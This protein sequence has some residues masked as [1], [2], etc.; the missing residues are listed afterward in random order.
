MSRAGP[1]CRSLLIFQH[2]RVL[3]A[4]LALI[5]L[6]GCTSWKAPQ[7]AVE[8]S[9]SHP[10]VIGVEVYRRAESERAARLQEEV[11]R[12]RVDLRQ[13]E[14]ALVEAESGLRGDLTRADAVSSLAEVRI[15]VERS[16]QEAP[17]RTEEIAE[18]RAKL[19]DADRLIQESHFGAAL[20][21]TYRARRIAGLLHSEAEKLKSVPGARFIKDNHVNLRAGPSTDD[22]IVGVLTR[23]A[24]LFPEQWQGSWVLV[25]TASGHVGWVHLSLIEAP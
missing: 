5:L 3:S 19:A 4:W 25:R 1:T 10:P 24:P 7:P 13:A 22:D 9:R 18:A 23:G 11:E 16:T 15:Q 17:W 14:E 12:L 21:L 2:G 8:P 20:F 6:A